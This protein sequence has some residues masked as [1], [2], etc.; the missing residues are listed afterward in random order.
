MIEYWRQIWN[1]RTFENTDI[2][3]PFGFVQ[4]SFNKLIITNLSINYGYSYQQ[5][6]TIVQQLEDFHGFDGIKHLI[7]VMFQIMS[8]QMYLWLLLWIYVMIQISK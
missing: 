1:E 5:L 6:P 2:Q 4:V 7:L 8:F 3:F